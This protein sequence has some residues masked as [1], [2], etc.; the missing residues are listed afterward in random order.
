M[1]LVPDRLPHAPGLW[2][3]FGW[4]N[5]KAAL[6]CLR[7]RYGASRRR[8]PVDG[9][10]DANVDSRRGIARLGRRTRG[11]TPDVGRRHHHRSEIRVRVGPCRG[12][13]HARGGARSR[14]KRTAGVHQE[15]ILRP[16]CAAQG[17]S[18]PIGAERFVDQ[19]SGPWLESLAAAGLVDAVDAFC[20]IHRVFRNGGDRAPAAGGKATG[21]RAHVHAE[22]LSDMGAA[23]RAAKWGALLWRIIWKVLERQAGARSQPPRRRERPRCCCRPR[24]FTLRQTTPPPVALLREAGV[25]LAVATDSNPGTS[26]CCTSILLALNMACTLFGLTLEEALSGATRQARARALGALDDIRISRG[27]KVRR[28]RVVAYR[29][30]RGTVLRHGRESVRGRD[31]S[32]KAQCG[33]YASSGDPEPCLRS[34]AASKQ[35]IDVQAAID[36]PFTTPPTAQETNHAMPRFSSAPAAQCR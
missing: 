19:V 35:I 11:Q 14:R 32:G 7:R 25:A 15:D 23:E 33:Q 26:P 10:G 1:T 28:H 31:V 5:S 3:Q 4:R 12:A 27:R 30:P 9:A 17:I 8:H 13:P 20:E 6:R 18:P 22:Q 24:I 36:A 21:L 34:I 29:A 2:G 16:A